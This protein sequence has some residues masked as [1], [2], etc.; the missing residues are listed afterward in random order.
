MPVNV[1]A[2]DAAIDDIRAG[3]E[4]GRFASESAVS[5]GVVLRI[6]A[7]LSWSVYDTKI[8]IPEYPVEGGRV[9]FA[10]CDRP[11]EP[12]AYIEV[13]N[14]DLGDESERQLFQYAFMR[15]V[16]LAILTSGKEWSFFLPD[17]RG[18]YR[19]RCAYKLDLAQRGTEECRARFLRYLEFEAVASGRAVEAAREDYQAAILARQIKDVLPEAWR[20]L[21][22]EPDDLLVDL[23]SDSVSNLCGYRPDNELVERFLRGQLRVAASDPTPAVPRTPAAQPRTTPVRVVRQG[24]G[25]YWFVVRGETFSARNARD[26]LIQILEQMHRRNSDFARKFADARSRVGG[27]RPYLAP[28]RE[29]LY[30]DRPHLRQGSKQDH[31]LSWG[32]WVGLNESRASIEK[33]IRIACDAVGFEFGRDLTINLGGD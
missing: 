16:P 17:Q 6:L 5:Q 19:E 14:K 12:I 18:D 33:I 28:T 15:G 20:R 1:E 21:L 23:L 26:V 22:E 25:S 2:L 27:K 11:G 8:V 29:D 4:D 3:I 24:E 10:L 7:M 13:K 30:P 31:Q 32:Y 9:D